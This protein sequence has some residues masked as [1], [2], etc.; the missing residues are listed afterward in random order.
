MLHANFISKILEEQ[1]NKVKKAFVFSFGEEKKKM[2]SNAG[3]VV[4]QTGILL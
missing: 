3:E 4:E 2:S 1:E